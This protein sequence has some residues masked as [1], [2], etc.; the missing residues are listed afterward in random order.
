MKDPKLNSKQWKGISVANQWFNQKS[1]PTFGE[2][3]KVLFEYGAT[4]PFIV[5]QPLHVTDIEL[6]PG[7][8]ILNIHL[9][10]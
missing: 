1:M 2:N 6:A 9:I 8:Q 7:E 5:T 4:M 3:G 10:R